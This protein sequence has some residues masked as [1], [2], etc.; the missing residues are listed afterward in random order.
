MQKLEDILQNTFWL[1]N[2]REG[3]KEIIES[4]VE[5]N[6]TLVFM[7]TGWGK[8]LTYQLPWVYL[9]GLT[10]IISPLISLMKDQIDKLNDLRINAKLIN[11]TISY[12]EQQDIL[13]ELSYWNKNK[14]KFLY[15]APERLNNSNFQRIIK[16]VKIALIAI[17]EVHCI[18]QW[19]H[20]FRPSYMK[21]KIFIE[22][23][24]WED[25]LFPVVWLTATAT[26][27]V[28][29][30]IVDRMWL[31]KYR[32]FTKWFDRKNII[33]IVREISKKEEKLKKVLEILN[34]TPWN[35][36]I[37]C[38]SRKVTKEVYDF[39][40]SNNID[41]WIYTWAMNSGDRESTQNDFM[42][43]IHRVI[44]A[45]NA[46]GMWID[47]KDIRYVIHY[48]L[49]WSIENY[50]QEVW[51]AGRDWKKSYWVVIASYWDTKIQEFFI[52][53][54]NPEKE[55]I[56]EFY[57]YLYKDYKIWE[58]KWN[59]VLKTYYNMAVESWIW[60][61]M[62]VW[63]IIKI[64]EK[65]WILNRWADYDEEEWFRWKWLTIF[66]EKRKHWSILIDWKHQDLLRE[67]AYYK[68][69]QIKKLLFYPSCRK[70]FILDYFWDEE[71]LKDLPNNCWTC[72]Y[73]LEKG[74]LMSW[75]VENLVNLS[76]FEIVLDVVKK[77]DKRYWL[78][79]IVAFLRW[80]KE[81]RIFD[82][83]LDKY[84]EY[85]VLSEYN[86]ELIE[87][88]IEALI[89]RD[90]IEKTTGQYPL[91]WLTNIWI[92]S[93]K[94]EAILIEDEKELQAYLFMR[95]KNSGFRK[96]RTKQGGWEL[97][98]K[99]PKWG[100]YKETLKLF[101]EWKSFKEIADLKGVKTI[102]IETHFVKLYDDNDITLNDLLKIVNFD[103]IVKVKN[104]LD[105]WELELDKLRP[106]KDKLEEIWENEISYFE[107]KTCICM[108]N[109]KDL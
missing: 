6:D 78:K 81:K 56:L 53:N 95:V 74:K 58:G 23:L 100:T 93:L 68:L 31:S 30:D 70:R 39:L 22:L 12:S 33:L 76:V 54:S 15:I 63:T 44:V 41:A 7:P 37:Y 57:D 11:S 43:D 50:Y 92:A 99:M 14:I 62:K 90:F 5:W 52:E 107:I 21:I 88:L 17:D 94:N 29:K 66:Q 101:K 83:R 72:D 3:Q 97:R 89:T 86:A 91:L 49:P 16:N 64:L 87:A 20:D 82:W 45:T 9:E 55:E 19:W 42:D 51:R 10:I 46:F 75:K 61:D 106:I 24:R 79:L 80:S 105:K 25:D 1:Q 40:I 8:S 108:M 65:Y 34:T 109:K 35:W 103:N 4:I 18:S 77:F 2:F 60:S 27:K 67:E 38:S 28:R 71:D 73:C 85:W 96:N 102:T 98:I 36:I 48:N 104:I 13:N 47:K 32:E 84:S 59:V 26:K 69:N